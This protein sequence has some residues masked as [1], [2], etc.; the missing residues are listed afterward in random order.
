MFLIGVNEEKKHWLPYQLRLTLLN[1]Q[2]NEIVTGTDPFF[3]LAQRSRDIC[4]QE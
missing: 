3:K 1:Y 4:V 2:C